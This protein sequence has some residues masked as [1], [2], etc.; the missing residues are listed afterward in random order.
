VLRPRCWSGRHQDRGGRPIRLRLGSKSVCVNYYL[1]ELPISPV[2]L[3]SPRFVSLITAP[4]TSGVA[5]HRPTK[6]VVPVS[7]QDC[8]WCPYMI[9]VSFVF[10]RLAYR[11]SSSFY[12]LGH[13]QRRCDVE[14]VLTAKG[15][16]STGDATCRRDQG[17]N[18]G[19]PRA[20]AF[21][22][23]AQRQTQRA[24]AAR[25]GCCVC[26][27]VRLVAAGSVH[28]Q[29]SVQFSKNCSSVPIVYSRPHKH[30]SIKRKHSSFTKGGSSESLAPCS[31]A[32]S[33]GPGYSGGF[34]LHG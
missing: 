9:T 23:P 17:P 11:P 5:S 30:S 32:R 1:F 4:F 10:Y 6:P 8:A 13:S 26:L 7:Q 28:N 20:N 22:L 2:V 3:R 15:H 14:R 19:T 18:R 33:S 24:E 34:G 31:A 27:I 29:N 21:S 12:S 16:G 25:E